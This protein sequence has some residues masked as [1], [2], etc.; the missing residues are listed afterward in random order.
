MPVYYGYSNAIYGT[1][2]TVNG[3]SQNYAYGPPVGSTWSFSG[4]TTAFHVRENSG[5]TLYNGDTTN[6]QVGSNEQIG[7]T[8]E[9][10]TLI[11]G[12][13]YQ[14]IWDYTF[15]IEAADGTLYRVGVID[16]DLNND[17]D[18]ND[19]GEDG[20]YLVFPDGVPPEG[21]DYTVN[22]IVEND[23]YVPHTDLGATI[24]CFTT[25]TMIET[26]RG[27]R[28]IETLTRGD[29]ILTRDNGYQPLRWI[30]SKRV[31]AQGDLAP[32]L[33]QPGSVGN[34][35]ALKVSPMHRMLVSDWRVELMTG[36]AQALVPARNLVNGRDILRRTGGWVTYAHILFDQHQIVFAEGAPSE[37]LHPGVCALDALQQEARAEVIAL[38]P[39]LAQDV[40]SYGPAAAAV[41]KGYQATCIARLSG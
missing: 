18:L 1:Q 4:S 14:T 40:D 34:T 23:A 26:D 27:P 15:E 31:R 17:D 33:F 13:Y 37:S 25:G 5:A 39:E 10:V 38:F 3:A 35:R 41:V 2:S 9:Q 22:G 12:T 21:V 24:V 20:Y 7:G 36:E 32:V 28:A 16:V 8:W 6:E 19:A 29:R 30:G 11:D